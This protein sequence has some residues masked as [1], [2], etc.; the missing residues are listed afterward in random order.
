M[1]SYPVLG[2]ANY[3]SR[4]TYVPG[5]TDVATV[6]SSSDIVAGSSLAALVDQNLSAVT[7]FGFGASRSFAADFGEALAP[8]MAFFRFRGVGWHDLTGV[9]LR[10]SPNSDLSTPT[11]DATLLPQFPAAWGDKIPV[12]PVLVATW[13][14]VAGCQYAEFDFA[15][16]IGDESLEIAFAYLGEHV[17]LFNA[18]GGDGAYETH[19]SRIAVEDLSS[20]ILSGAQADAKIAGE[21]RR[22]V[23]EKIVITGNDFAYDEWYAKLMSAAGGNPVVYWAD[24]TETDEARIQ[25]QAFLAT[26]GL[27]QQLELGGQGSNAGIWEQEL[28][29]REIL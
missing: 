12:R 3:L 6:V 19:A 14:A 16:T 20:S 15:R 25:W 4:R 10:L 13:A 27:G 21:K 24:A 17:R 11:K 7:D 18:A 28:P 23:L 2:Y 26:V 8:T 29:I 22:S 9:R 1:S 5:G